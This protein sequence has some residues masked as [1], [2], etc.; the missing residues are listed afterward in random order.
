MTC[1]AIYVR[2]YRGD[3]HLLQ[4]L[5]GADI[6]AVG[7]AHAGTLH[8]HEGAPTAVVD[9]ADQGLTLPSLFGST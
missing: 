9:A 5:V 4:E 1:Q 8:G 3:A 2:P 6:A 7:G